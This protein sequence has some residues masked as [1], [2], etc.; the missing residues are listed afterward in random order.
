MPYRQSKPMCDELII[1]IVKP[2]NF[3]LSLGLYLEITIIILSSHNPLLP[4]ILYLSQPF[5]LPKT[6]R[7]Q[8][9]SMTLTSREGFTRTPSV[10]VLCV[11]SPAG[12]T[13]TGVVVYPGQA[14]LLVHCW[15]H[16]PMDVTL[17]PTRPFQH[18]QSTVS[19][20]HVSFSTPV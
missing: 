14:C 1:G 9:T 12:V 16:W 10:W 4:K 13:R 19:R 20:C 5:D 11:W 17:T 3:V 6:W 15:T 7:N 18:H 8:V 2:K